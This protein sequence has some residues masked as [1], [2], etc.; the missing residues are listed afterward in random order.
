MGGFFFIGIDFCG[1]HI[2]AECVQAG[3]VD[4]RYILHTARGVNLI[5]TLFVSVQPV[6]NFRDS[7]KPIVL[8]AEQREKNARASENLT[9][10]PRRGGKRAQRRLASIACVYTQDAWQCRRKHVILI[11]RY[12]NDPTGGRPPAPPHERRPRSANERGP[13]RI[14]KP[15]ERPL[16]IKFLHA[17]IV[18]LNYYQ[19]HAKGR[20][21]GPDSQATNYIGRHRKGPQKR[22][23]RPGGPSFIVQV[24]LNFS[25]IYKRLHK[26]KTARR[27]G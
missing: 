21:I 27:A 20:K 16:K 22:P 9:R 2:K 14:Y 5:H 10:S 17:R 8:T 23:E 18:S 3:F 26:G 7:S 11:S 15:P 1:Y 13:V 24:Y 25:D 12:Q 19:R 4:N 6:S